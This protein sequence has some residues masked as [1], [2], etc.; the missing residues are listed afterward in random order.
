[1]NRVLRGARR[2]LRRRRWRLFVFKLLAKRPPPPKKS[3]IPATEQTTPPE[4]P[5]P[6][7]IPVSAGSSDGVAPGAP[8]VHGDSTT[9]IPL[10]Y[11]LRLFKPGPDEPRHVA[12]WRSSTDYPA[13]APD[14]QKEALKRKV[15]AALVARNPRLQVRQFP[16]EQI[17]QFER[18]S[19]EQA[20]CKYRHVELS[21]Q[22]GGNGLQIVLRDDE[23]A[24]KVPFWYDG[25]KATETFRELWGYLEIICREA[26][27]LIY[28]PQ[29]DRTFNPTTGCEEVLAQYNGTVRQ[30]R[31]TW[32]GEGQER[33]GPSPT[34]SGLRP[35][36]RA[37]RH[38]LEIRQLTA[39]ED[40]GVVLV[41]VRENGGSCG[42]AE[43]SIRHDHVEG[44]SSVPVAYL[45][46]WYVAPQFRGH[47]IGRRLLESAEK[48][49][50]ARGLRELASDVNLQHEQI[51]QA[52]LACG[53]TE[54]GRAG[55][56]IKPT[57]PPFYD[58]TVA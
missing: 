20:R 30:F 24:V 6:A 7:A 50:A 42:F 22:E 52:H 54:T 36:R 3:R 49:A 17:A 1:M 44:A 51:L 12:A 37:E 56:F 8:K 9:A 33:V 48:W 38:R 11:D 34:Q 46:G 15:V 35:H 43:V 14:P 57:P 45:K 27:Y 31:E 28:D 10:S 25:Q 53:F 2:V 23:A 41:A 47:G 21:V 13:T 55:H 18:I 4:E 32:P 19:T 5:L 26:G 58:T 29:M 16:Y 40:C 39:S